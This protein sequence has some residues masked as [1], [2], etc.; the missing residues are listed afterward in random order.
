MQL[1]F[2]AAEYTGSLTGKLKDFKGGIAKANKIA[3]TYTYTAASN[4]FSTLSLPGVTTASFASGNEID[5]DDRYNTFNSIADKN[6]QDPLAWDANATPSATD[7]IVITGTHTITVPDLIT[8]AALS[9]TIDG[10]VANTL[11]VG[12]G[13]TG[14]L[15]VGSGGLTNGSSGNIS[16]VLTINNGANVNITG[17]NLATFGAITNNGAVTVQ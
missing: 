7:D 3:G 1:A 4:G 8:A 16:G 5:I 12:G 17:G 11:V 6:W 10:S 9:V 13:S 14:I 2:L 15:N